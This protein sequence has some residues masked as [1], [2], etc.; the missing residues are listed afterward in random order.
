MPKNTFIVPSTGERIACKPISS[1]ILRGLDAERT[2]FPKRPTYT[3]EYPGGETE[4]AEHDET[5]IAEMPEEKE[6]W[7][8][9]VKEYNRVASEFQERWMKTIIILGI[10]EQ[11]ADGWEADY[12]YLGIKLP[13]DKR[14]LRLWWVNNVLLPTDEDK[15]AFSETI[16]L[17]STIGKE[18]LA[19][20]EESFPGILRWYSSQ[21]H[22]ENVK[23]VADGHKVSG[24]KSDG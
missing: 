13:E 9:Y 4:E 23:S 7:E 16:T 2:N 20:I 3:I 18:D 6:K 10:T 14:E 21:Q 8:A 17:I 5:T 15:S 11:P 19:R 24:S 12:E 1:K 22:E